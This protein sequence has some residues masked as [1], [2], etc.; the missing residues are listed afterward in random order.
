LPAGDASFPGSDS[1]LV[2]AYDG[3]TGKAC[4]TNADCRKAGGPGVAECSSTALGAYGPYYPTPVCILPSCDPGNG[5]AAHYCDGPDDPS[6]PG[7]CVPSGGTGT[8]QGICLPRCEFKADGMPAVGCAGKDSCQ[9][10]TF[11]TDATGNAVG[12]GYCFGGCVADGDCPSGSVCQ[13]DEGLCVKARTT[14]SKKVGD[15]CTSADYTSGA[16]D[17]LYG[18]SG[19][20]FC[21]SFCLVGGG[22]GCPGGYVC[23]AYELT[24]AGFTKETAGMGGQ[25]VPSCGAGQTCPPSSA[26]S[27]LYAAGPDCQPQ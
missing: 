23:E 3:T 26:C 13:I 24:S 1:G 16:C 18:T 8:T 9:A 11:G 14:R 22:A 15:A 6:S 21:S 20:G 10:Y 5:Q 17:C 2:G 4:T 25:C 27:S 12:Y 19:S 7:I